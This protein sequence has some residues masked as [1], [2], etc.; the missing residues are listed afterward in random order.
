MGSLA[1][2]P[3][4]ELPLPGVSPVSQAEIPLSWEEIFVLGTVLT[5]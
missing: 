4:L 1:D 5:S 2:P 3:L